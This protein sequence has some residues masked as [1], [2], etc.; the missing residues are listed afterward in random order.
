MGHGYTVRLGYWMRKGAGGCVVAAIVGLRLDASWRQ[1]RSF[2]SGPM[3][4]RRSA[5]Q[6]EG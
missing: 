1:C 2:T 4:G 6:C 5:G 3:G